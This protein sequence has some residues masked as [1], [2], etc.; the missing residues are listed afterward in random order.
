MCASMTLAPFEVD[1]V[2]LGPLVPDGVADGGAEA[3]VGPQAIVVEHLFEIGLQLRLLGVGAGP[4]VALEGVG[5]EVRGHVD[6]GARVAVV[7][8][9]AA[10]PVGLLEDGE[11]VDARLLELDRSGDA[12]E[13]GPDDGDLGRARRAEMPPSHRCVHATTCP[14]PAPF[15]MFGEPS[16]RC[17]RPTA[18]CRTTAPV[19]ITAPMMK[20]LC[21]CPS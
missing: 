7:P 5:V 6:L 18:F 4:V 2:R 8:P 21:L 16:A 17:M 3:E 12:G 9:G 13:A 11:G 19:G 1:G 10:G 20:E 14:A 15:G